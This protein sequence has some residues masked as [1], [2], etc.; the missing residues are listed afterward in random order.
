MLAMGATLKEIAKEYDLPLSGVKYHTHS[1]YKKLS[2]DNKS[3]AISKAA[4]LNLIKGA[5][6]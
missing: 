2:V 5:A 6:V 4:A 1:I 3:E